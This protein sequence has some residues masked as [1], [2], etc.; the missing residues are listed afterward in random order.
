[1]KL[2]AILLVSLLVPPAIGQ[3]DAGGA[4]ITP[5]PENDTY[6]LLAIGDSLAEGLPGGLIEGF[7]RSGLDINSKHRAV[8]SLTRNEFDA[9]LATLTEAIAREPLHI[10]VVLLGTYDR[11]SLRNEAGKRV[12][13]AAED[14]KDLYGQR[15]DRF[16]KALKKRNVAIYW[17]GLPVMRRA[18]EEAQ[19]KNDIIRSTARDNN[20]RYI[21][22]HAVTADENG[23]YNAYGPDIAGKNVLL[24][25]PD[26]IH[27]TR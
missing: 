19:L 17:I 18:D 4:Y 20:I 21:D 25:T 5:F 22:V 1:M 9:D 24:R 10:V 12:S 7:G 23:N 27:L 3:E 6:R 13:I 14:W 15:L 16:A 2:A 11:G 8:Q 26:G